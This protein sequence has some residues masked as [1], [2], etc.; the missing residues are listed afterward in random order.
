MPAF[1]RPSAISASLRSRGL[2]SCKRVVAASAETSSCTRAGSTTEPPVATLRSAVDEIVRRRRRGSS[3][4]SRCHR[5]LASRSMA[6]ST[7]TWA[8]RTRIPMSG[9]RRGWPGRLET[10]DGLSRR[11]PDVDH[12][13]SGRLGTRSSSASASP[14]WPTTS[15]PGRLEETRQI[16][17]RSRTSSSATTTRSAARVRRDR[18]RSRLGLLLRR[19]CLRVWT[20]ADRTS[21]YLLAGRRFWRLAAMFGTRSTRSKW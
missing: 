8:D 4:G 6:C 7:S 15:K 20:R 16:P 14:A 21:T 12:A 5:P 13:T 9:T 2:R 19:A 17:A 18:R 11:H 10:L 3:A 1:E